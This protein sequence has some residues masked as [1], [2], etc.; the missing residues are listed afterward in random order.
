MNRYIGKTRLW[1]FSI[2][3]V[4]LVA[5]VIA[6]YVAGRASLMPKLREAERRASRAEEM[7]DESWRQSMEAVKQMEKEVTGST[8]GD[9][10]NNNQ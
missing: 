5:L 7:V 4:F 8:R 2:R 1:Q 3:T 9:A 10:S 6:A